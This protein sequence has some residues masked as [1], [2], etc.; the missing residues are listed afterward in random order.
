MSREYTGASNRLLLVQRTPSDEVRGPLGLL[1]EGCSALGF[2]KVRSAVTHPEG[3]R[4]KSTGRK[5]LIKTSAG[6]RTCTFLSIREAKSL[7]VQ[8]QFWHCLR[9]ELGFLLCTLHRRNLLVP[10]FPSR[11]SLVKEAPELH[12]MGQALTRGN[13]ELAGQQEKLTPAGPDLGCI[14]T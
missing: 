12:S 3:G 1:L 13:P 7:S 9:T 2:R 8:V 5:M 10:F 14:L 11:L 6:C 4:C